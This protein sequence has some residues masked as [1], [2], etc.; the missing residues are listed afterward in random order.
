MYSTP[1]KSP[2]E[3]T[4][5]VPALLA[6]QRQEAPSWGAGLGTR[7]GEARRRLKILSGNFHDV[8]LARL[9]RT[10]KDPEVKS[11]MQEHIGVVAN[12]GADITR[13][14][15]CVYDQHPRRRF[16]DGTEDENKA[17]LDLNKLTRWRAK[18]KDLNA[19]AWFVGPVLEMPV[20]VRDSNG[21][22]RLN[23]RI[24]T[25]DRID[26][27]TADDDPLGPPIAAAYPWIE[28]GKRVIK[29]V[30][31]ENEYTFSADDN[32]ETPLRTEPHG[33]TEPDGKTPRF[34]GTLHR[35]D[36][37]TDPD[38]YWTFRQ[39]ARLV[40]ATEEA[41]LIYCTASWIRKSQNRKLLAAIGNLNNLPASTKL[42]PE[43]GVMWMVDDSEVLPSF[44]VSDLNTPI[45]GFAA[46]YKWIAGV[47]IES[48]GVP[49]SEVDFDFAAGAGG[50]S[51]TALNLQHDRKVKL[52]ND[53]IPFA[54]ESEERGQY[55]LAA[56][57]K[58]AGIPGAEKLPDL[59]E[60][61]ERFQ[62]EF[63]ELARVEDPAARQAELDWKLSRGMTTD[64]HIY[65]ME[66]PELT[67]DE[68]HAAVMENLE[69]QAETNEFKASR[70]VDPA[71]EMQDENQI[72][73]AM[74]GDPEPDED[75]EDDEET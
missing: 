18:S 57:A 51:V 11:R 44:S 47:T 40:D 14:L 6:A 21:V 55:N 58:R 43:K 64:A 52:R 54:I 72:T 62:V 10:Y 28:N 63:P 37:P 5:G 46:H 74:R 69:R 65:Q 16:R 26:V 30:D 25:A 23:R 67:L 7:K 15:A 36:V 20:A 27:Q 19:K 56:V 34:P 35:Y 31:Q 2:V 22:M 42:D 48:Y 32:S 3:L 60:F 9:C 61:A 70:N 1:E 39:H 66:H 53:Q 4:T 68:C 45:D 41:G 49:Q 12:L 73:G 24:I 17:I 13:A 59:S 50:S 71:A 75:D 8:I 38:D 29:I 33:V